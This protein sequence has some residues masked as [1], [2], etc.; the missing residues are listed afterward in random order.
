MNFTM[1]YSS[2]SY[3]LT[4]LFLKFWL[5]YTWLSAHRR[6]QSAVTCFKNVLQLNIKRFKKLGF[7]LSHRQPPIQFCVFALNFN[8]YCL[9]WF[10][11]QTWPKVNITIDFC[12]F[13]LVLI[14]NFSLNWKF[15]FVEPNLPQKNIYGQKTKN[16]HHYWV[17]KS[18]S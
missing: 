3:N 13:K 16:E 14:P 17:I 15:W 5:V 8:L 4:H 6:H 10:W 18:W 2:L 9:F 11:D 7:Q 12:I 1:I